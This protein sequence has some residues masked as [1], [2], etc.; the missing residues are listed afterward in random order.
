MIEWF[1]RNSVAANLLMALILALGIHAVFF[2]IPL[3]AYPDVALDTVSISMVFRGA[4]PVEV[5]EGIV[6]RIEEAISDLTGIKRIIAHANEGKARIDIEVEKGH[7]PPTLLDDIKNRVDAISTFPLDTER[8]VYSILQ[9]RIKVI[10]V[11]ISADLPERELREL[12]ER[13]RDDLLAL[14][15]ISQVDL[16]GVRSHEIA[17]EVKQDTLERFGLGFDDITEAIRNTSGDYPAGSLKTRRGEILLRT[18]GQ[19]YTMEDFARIPVITHPD[20]TRL[21]LADI[22]GIKDGFV[23]DPS[24]ARFNGQPAVLLLVYRTTGQNTTT[25]AR[26]VRNYVDTVRQHMPPGITIDYWWDDSRRIQNW[27]SLLTGSAI[28]ATGIILLILGLFLRPLVAALVFIGIPIS[29]M[30]AL[31]LMPVF[32]VTI[33][34]YTLFA[35]ILVLGIVVDDAIVTGENIY[36]HLQ[37]GED[38]VLAAI[39]GTHDIA[40]PVTL[41]VLTTIAVFVPLLFVEG[42]RSTMF[43]PGAIVVILVLLF[44]LVGSKLILPA[45]MKHVRVPVDNDPSRNRLARIQGRV[46]DSLMW[47]IRT[48]Y[49]PLL[50]RALENRF[51]T[52]SLFVGIS[53]VLISFFFSGRYAFV[54]FPSAEGEQVWVNLTMPAGT[55]A[56]IMDR[57]LSRISEAA[58][59]LQDKYRDAATGESVIRNILLQNGWDF[60]SGV[61]DTGPYKGGI[62]LQLAPWTEHPVPVSNAELVREWRLIT[63]PIPGTK[64]LRFQFDELQANAS[65]GIRITGDDLQ[66]LAEAAAEI[67]AR[68]AEYDGVLN[69]RDSFDAER[70]EIV[71]TLHPE[72]ELLG[73]SVSDLGK[74]VRWAFFGAEAQRI[75]RGRDDVRVMVRYPP[76]E[77]L[78]EENLFR[79]KI[80]TLSGVEV[81]LT[82]VADVTMGRGLSSIRRVDRHRAADVSA[83]IDTGG[84]DVNRIMSHMK[85]FFAGLQERYPGIRYSLEGEQREQR[86]SFTSLTLGAALVFF[87]IYSLLAIPLRSYTEPIIVMAVIPFS[88]VG[89]LIGHIIMDMEL[90]IISVMGFLALSGVVINDNLVLLDYINQKRSEGLSAA[91]AA[92]IA[93][94][95]RFRPILLTSLTTFAGLIPLIFGNDIQAQHLLPMAVSLGIGILFSTPLTLFLTPIVYTILDDLRGT[96]QSP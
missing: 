30:G 35:F 25:L 47:S 21:T 34:I 95:A 83:D 29:F 6:V 20:G 91:K 37:R 24:Y 86:E 80:R 16:M 41:G 23:E 92:R 43:G 62:V 76:D 32:G 78:S 26:D 45:H 88:M 90:S 82:T 67:K 66:D 18:E 89:A 27:L 52:L 28:H 79:M 38:P 71:L 57:H 63:G 65:I 7:D 8:P 19:A 22:A 54:F 94:M 75:Q 13:V 31:A 3:E 36:I 4:T 69:I 56:K 11:A 10:S 60:L 2:R 53:F 9:R 77:R 1:T 48:F 44:S 73:I 87:V 59:R 70:E 93:G 55:P 85:P 46:A 96:G 84:A 15:R 74:Q 5:E 81:P 58:H 17:M 12:G 72:A 40:V 33:N 14:P 68:L 51:L 42:E 39:H 64:E 49:Q 61:K 50:V